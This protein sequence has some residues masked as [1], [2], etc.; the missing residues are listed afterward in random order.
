MS[1]SNRSFGREW[2]TLTMR[3]SKSLRQSKYEIPN[4]VIRDRGDST[5]T[6]LT[7]LAFRIMVSRDFSFHVES[8]L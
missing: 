8:E 1:V 7:P 4:R 6:W 3:E 5:E 2:R